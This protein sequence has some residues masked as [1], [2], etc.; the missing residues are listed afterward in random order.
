MLPEQ[1][2]E[3]LNALLHQKQ[4]ELDYYQKHSNAQW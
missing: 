3:A 2:E 1:E 4:I